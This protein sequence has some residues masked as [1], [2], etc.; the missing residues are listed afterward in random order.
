M[1]KA[2]NQYYYHFL[3]DVSAELASIARE[4]ENSVFASPRTMLTHSRVFVEGVVQR[5]L[6]IENISDTDCDSLKDRLFL[7]K[8][9]DLVT[10]EQLTAL[11]QIRKSGN[12][13][14][15]QTRAFRYVEALIAWE[16]LYI[17]IK[18]FVEVYGSPSIKVPE[19]RDPAI[20]QERTYEIQELE[21][22]LKELEDRLVHRFQ[23]LTDTEEEADQPGDDD[24]PVSLPGET[25]IRRIHYKEQSL[26]IPYFLRD[27]FLLPQRFENSERF[28]IALGGEQQARIMSELPV[29]LE[30]ISANVKRFHPNNEQVMFDDLVKFIQQEFTRKKITHERPGE[31]FLFFRDE[32][33]I[34]TERLAGIPLTDEHFSGFPNFLRQMQEDGMKY[35]SQL[36]QEL[37]ILAKYDRVG[38]GTVEKLFRQ[39]QD[40]G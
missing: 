16:A 10:E 13:A 20:E 9:N 40:K 34:M 31:L 32:Y 5:V 28:M 35:V 38:I 36:P 24:S 11:H 7:L 22:R 26:D 33:I 2:Q 14:S 18:W 29:N 17:V 25:T 4:L 30:G 39:L 8:E 6:Q 23:A 21:L 15:H 37:L 12:E 27:A 3:K 19:Y 1:K